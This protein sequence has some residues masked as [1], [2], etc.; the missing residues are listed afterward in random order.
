MKS[1]N[2][3]REHPELRRLLRLLRRPTKL[4]KEPL[5]ISLRDA[6]NASSALD[7][8][9]AIIRKALPGSS[10]VNELMRSAIIAQDFDGEKSRR[11]AASLGL[12]LRSYFRYRLAAVDLIA[13]A[14]ER[15]L[16]EPQDT[17]ERKLASLVNQYNARTAFDFYARAGDEPRGRVAYEMLRLAIGAGR[18]ITR[19]MVEQCDGPWRVLAMA[20]LGERHVAGGRPKIARRWQRK[21]REAL[22]MKP[23]CERCGTALSESDSAFICSYECTFCPNCAELLRLACPNCGG[24]LLARPRRA[25]GRSA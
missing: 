21:L 17:N 9:I 10:E 18:P 4:E 23:E 14:V 13:M 8:L 16:Q 3:H 7:A 19:Q 12:S 6:M 15:E 24:E 5:A 2:V 22:Q 11:V 20:A 25:H 1:L